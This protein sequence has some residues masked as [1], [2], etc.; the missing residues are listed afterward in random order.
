VIVIIEAIGVATYQTFGNSSTLITVTYSIHPVT[1]G[2]YW[3][4]SK[5]STVTNIEVS[6]AFNSSRPV[7]SVEIEAT[8]PNGS[9]PA[10][11]NAE[12]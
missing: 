5:T 4:I 11:A 1:P 3:F 7:P 8:P 12:F 9:K 2:F 6:A 10:P